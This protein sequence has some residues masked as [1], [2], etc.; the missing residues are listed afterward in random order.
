MSNN[1]YWGSPTSTIDWCETNYEITEYI[2]EFCMYK[3]NHNLWEYERLNA[4]ER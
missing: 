3:Q 1:G 2:A 4:F